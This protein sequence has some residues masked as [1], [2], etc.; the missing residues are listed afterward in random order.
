MRRSGYAF[1][2]QCLYNPDYCDL[3]IEH[4]RDG[5]MIESFSG[6][7]GVGPSTVYKWKNENP[8]FAEAI[9]IGFRAALWHW[10]KVLKASAEG[11]SKGNAA[12]IIFKL[13][14]TFKEW[15]RDRQDLEVTGA[16][17]IQVTTNVGSSRALPDVNGQVVRREVADTHIRNMIE[18]GRY[19][20]METIEQTLLNVVTAPED[21]DGTDLL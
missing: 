17:I 15:Y 13:K 5:Y 18:S 6:R 21:G 19:V 11:T 4:M 14:N 1:R 10:E 20:D 9:E 7:I 2:S 16:A 3:V 8:E 12:S